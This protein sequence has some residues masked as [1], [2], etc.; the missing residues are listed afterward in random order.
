MCGVTD[1]LG[2]A[3]A[4][5]TMCAVTDHLGWRTCCIY[6]LYVTDRRQDTMSHPKARSLVLAP[7]LLQPLESER[8]FW[9]S[10]AQTLQRRNRLLFFPASNIDSDFIEVCLD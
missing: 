8:F 3:H 4:A 1:H 2:D 7:E 10:P 5:S 6:H 9:M